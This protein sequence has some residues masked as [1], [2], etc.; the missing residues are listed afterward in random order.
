MINKLRPTSWRM[1]AVLG[2]LLLLAMTVAACAQPIAPVAPA[3][4]AGA[5]AEA[6]TDTTAADAAA[7]T[8]TVTA[9][10]EAAAEPGAEATTGSSS[11]GDATKETTTEAAAVPTPAVPPVASGEWEGMQ[12]GFTAEGYPF[13]GE[14][15]APITMYEYSDY[16][17]P[18]CARYFV[19]TEPAINDNYVR[20]GK[21]R[22]VF[23]DFPIEELHPNAP[24]AHRAILCVAEQGADLYWA[25]HNKLFQTQTEWSN[26][27]DPQ[28]VFERLA[29]EAGAD[30]DAYKQ[31]MTTA[32]TEK[33][34]I[35]DAC[36]GRRAGSRRNR[37]AQ[38]LLCRPRRRLLSVGRRAAVRP[39]RAAT[40]IRC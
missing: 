26:S 21:V 23:R 38:F 30:M 9:T 40:S 12:V 33:Q 19:Q 29:D 14:P 17:C 28:P 16:Q 2:A 1:L 32:E 24:A 11:N 25:M 39:V 35:I 22:V 27:T 7:A 31:C 6:T 5:A 3:G 8:A 20:T 4:S 36:A 13:R 10:E 34:P 37:H 15:N 18:F